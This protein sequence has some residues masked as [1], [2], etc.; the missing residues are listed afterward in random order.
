MLFVAFDSSLAISTLVQFDNSAII[1]NNNNIRIAL[2]V[3]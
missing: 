1:E 2:F 3:N